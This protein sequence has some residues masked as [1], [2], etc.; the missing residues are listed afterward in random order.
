MRKHTELES[1]GAPQPRATARKKNISQ[2]GFR[3]RMELKLQMEFIQSMELPLQR[4]IGG[5]GGGGSGVW[6][7]GC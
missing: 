4:G 5:L 1:R 6:H 2:M 7:L 3:E